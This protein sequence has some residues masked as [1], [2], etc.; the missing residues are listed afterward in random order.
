MAPTVTESGKDALIAKHIE[1]HPD[2]VKQG[3]GWYRLKERGVPVYAIIGATS[4]SL[5]NLDDVADVYGVSRAAVD[6]A[7]AYCR[8]YQAAIAARQAANHAA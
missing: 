1:S 5:D 7:V 4:P 3:R 8:R 6:A 2:P